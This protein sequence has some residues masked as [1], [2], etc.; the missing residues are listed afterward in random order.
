[1]HWLSASRSDRA[2]A[3]SAETDQI[4]GKKKAASTRW[5]SFFDF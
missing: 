4:D 5:G 3:K 2:G 1:M